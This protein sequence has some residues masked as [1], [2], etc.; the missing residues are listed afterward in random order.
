MGVECSFVCRK[1]DTGYLQKNAT[2]QIL[3]VRYYY[4]IQIMGFV[5]D[6]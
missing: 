3:D 5:K 6:G 2:G 1:I 4:Y